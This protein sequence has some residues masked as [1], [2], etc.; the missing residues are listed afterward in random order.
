M[1]LDLILKDDFYANFK[2][3]IGKDKEKA[4]TIQLRPFSKFDTYTFN[5]ILY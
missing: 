2:T 5:S 1:Q 4:I 3:F